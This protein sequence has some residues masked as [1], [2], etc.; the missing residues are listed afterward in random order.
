MHVHTRSNETIIEKYFDIRD[1]RNFA[2]INS[3]YGWER[4][5]GSLSVQVDLSLS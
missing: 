2:V 4:E 1:E 5:A 3:Y